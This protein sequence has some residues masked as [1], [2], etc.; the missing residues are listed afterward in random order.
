MSRF[1]GNKHTIE[2]DENHVYRVDGIIKPGANQILKA[3]A[4]PKDWGQVPEYYRD[5]GLAVHAAIDLYLK[6]QLDEES[7]DPACI[8][9][10]NQF[11]AWLHKNEAAGLVMSERP[12]Y[13]E[14]YD[15]CGTVDLIINGTIFDYKCS[16]KID[17]DAEKQYR[18][19]G[20]AYRMLVKH[21]LGLDLPFKLMLLTGEGD[22]KVLSWECPLS[23]WD[24]VMTIYV[25]ENGSAQAK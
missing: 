8:P 17:K 21:D 15:F 20:S 14:P 3:V 7:L 2:L 9:Y 5:R 12:L 23:T 10:F 6:G 13:S 19:L 18:R 1:V 11:R 4:P 22:A 24:A 16:K 25:N